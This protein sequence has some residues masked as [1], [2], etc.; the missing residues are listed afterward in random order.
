MMNIWKYIIY[1][2]K[3]KNAFLYIKFNIFTSI[4]SC[5]K[6]CIYL[7]IF[8]IDNEN[9]SNIISFPHKILSF[10]FFFF[11]VECFLF[12]IKWK[13]I[14]RIK[15]FLKKKNKRKKDRKKEKKN[16]ILFIIKKKFFFLKNKENV[17]KMV[18]H[19]T[20]FNIIKKQKIKLIFFFIFLFFFLFFIFKLNYINNK[21]QNFYY[22]FIII[23]SF[24]EFISI[25]KPLFLFYLNIC[26][27]KIRKYKY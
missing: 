19:K 18:F 15:Y 6:N 11:F 12:Y 4:M 26:T 17:L 3:N 8:N 25:I 24:L 5:I 7:I 20:G 14:Q 2:E 1:K 9:S 23:F 13:M 21:N 22:K 10:F 27:I 16:K